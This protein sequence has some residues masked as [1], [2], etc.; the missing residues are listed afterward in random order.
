MT[1]ETV[2]TILFI[3]FFIFLVISFVYSMRIDDQLQKLNREYCLREFSVMQTS[4]LC[5]EYRIDYNDPD[6]SAEAY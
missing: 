4:D 6:Y 5:L 2:S 1:D 3:F